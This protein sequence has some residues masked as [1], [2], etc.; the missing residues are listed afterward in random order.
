MSQLGTQTLV[1]LYGCDPGC[2]DDPVAIR[3]AMLEAARRAGATVVTHGF[4]RFTPCGVSG[5][6][7]LAESHFAIH[8]W[9]EH[10]FAALDLFTCGQKMATDQCFP[11]L[12][13]KLGS[14]RQKTTVVARGEILDR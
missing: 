1:D 13:E 4:H 12:I 9:P 7:F 6:V 5:V 10:G 8:T 14:T 3:D 2:L 11:F